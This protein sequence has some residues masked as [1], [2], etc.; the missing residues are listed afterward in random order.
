[1]TCCNAACTFATGECRA[2]AGDCDV[3][4]SCS[5]DSAD[6]PADGFAG[7]GTVCRPAAGDCDVADNCDGQGACGPDLKSEDVCRAS[8]GSCDPAESCDGSGNDCPADVVTTD[9]GGDTVDGCCAYG[10]NAN[11]DADCEP[12]CGNGVSEDGEECD[13]GNNNETDSCT[14]QCTTR[15]AVP[16]V[17]QWGLVVLAL[18]L[19]AAAKVYFGRRQAIA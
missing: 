6:C 13:D 5:G 19:L 9:C 15:E 2:A 18:L 4:E 11:D 1:M 8:T 12:I 3:A 10:C 14:A 7:A 16:T 17:S